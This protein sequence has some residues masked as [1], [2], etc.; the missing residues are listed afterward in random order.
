MTGATTAGAGVAKGG[1]EAE[2]A[3]VDCRLGAHGMKW[4]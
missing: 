2:A 1:T 3:T 4:S